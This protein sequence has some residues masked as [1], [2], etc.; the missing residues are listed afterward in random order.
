MNT[1][2]LFAAINAALCS[3]VVF[4]AL[5]RLNAMRHDVLL[6]VRCEYAALVGGAIAAG[7]QPW[8]GEWPGWAS[9]GFAFSVLVG[10]ICSEHAWRRGPEDVVP[11]VATGKGEPEVQ[12]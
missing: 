7:V 2:Y 6:R 5:C 4:I 11:A 1:L 9:V 3:V 12:S 8:Y 10:L